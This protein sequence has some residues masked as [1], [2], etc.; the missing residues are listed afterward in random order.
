MQDEKIKIVN[1]AAAELKILTSIVKR[2]CRICKEGWDRNM[3]YSF[4][5]DGQETSHKIKLVTDILLSLYKE[6]WEPMT[7]IDTAGKVD[8]ISHTSICFRHREDPFNR[9]NGSNYSLASS[10]GGGK[11]LSNEC[12]CIETFQPNFVGFHSVPNTVLH[13]IEF[14]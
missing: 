14:Q 8:S 3:T 11:E 5:L 10:I 12:L 7:P 1:I 9:L 4:K 6:G 13:E 2:H